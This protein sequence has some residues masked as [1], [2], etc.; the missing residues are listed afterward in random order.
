VTVSRH[1]MSAVKAALL[2]CLLWQGV[3]QAQAETDLR[4][5]SVGRN[6]SLELK[7][8]ER[9]LAEVKL[10]TPSAKRGEPKL[11]EAQVEGR[12]VVEVRVPIK[13]EAAAEVW[14][15]TVGTTA[16]TTVWSGRVGTTDRDGEAG[17]EVSVEADGL[18]LYET[19]ARIVRCDGLPVRLF[20]RK[21]DFQTRRWREVAP[22]LP[23]PASGPAI[24]ARRG[25]P[26][27]PAG[28]PRVQFPFTM[29]SAPPA[30]VRTRDI[31]QLVA[32]LALNDGDV[33][34]VWAQRGFGDGRG[35]LLT[36]RS[37]TAGQVVVGLR[38]LP[39]DTR[40]HAQFLAH[41]RPR[42]LQVVLGAGADQRF[43]VTLSDDGG[44]DSYR[45]PFWIPLP[46]PVSSSCVTVVVREVTPGS[47]ARERNTLVWGDIDVFTDLDGEKGV[48]RLVSALEGEHCEP[49][50]G[51]V[52]AVGPGALP[53]LAAALGRVQGGS[54]ECVLEAVL[55]LAPE[56]LGTEQ[57]APLAAALPALLRS[58]PADQERTVLSLLSR[59]HAPPVP[60]LAAVLRDGEAATEQRARA[61]RA[62]AAVARPE[63]WQALI[64][65][66]GSGPPELRAV[67]R[68]LCASAPIDTA[69]SLLARLRSGAGDDSARRADMVWV[70]GALAARPQ[71]K[72][73]GVRELMIELGSAAGE[74]FEVRARALMALAAW[75]EQEALAALVQVRAK[76]P[77]AALRTVAARALAERRGP[78]AT[79]ALRAAIEDSDPGVRQIA[80]EALGARRDPGAVP[81]IIAGAKQEPWPAVRRAEIAALGQLC[82]QPATDLIVRAIERDVDDVRRAAMRG[83]V[84]CRDGRAPR[85][86][87]S[88]LGGQREKPPLRTQAALLLA[89]LKDPGT[90]STLAAALER[91]LLE[92][93]ADLALEAT[94][95]ATLR[96]LA[97]VGGP[98]AL[99]AALQLRSDPRPM[100]RRSASEALG[101]LCD[102]RAGAEA[103]RA[104]TRDPDPA[105]AAAATAALRRCGSAEKHPRPRS[106]ELK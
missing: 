102:P 9:R 105:V 56:R 78:E 19:A 7:A 49:R 54:L 87:L 21:F 20:T 96:A 83:L 65:Q 68:G 70:L 80:A 11:K 41:A 39:G 15:G 29:S 79:A 67:V 97:E 90:A 13:D 17:R 22:L 51:D 40:S 72:P 60:E 53:A 48:E 10:S 1:E 62:L 58:A 85:L 84:A 71:E 12:R 44:S 98:A 92:A 8:G 37:G 4:M 77:D 88:V 32:P 28:R 14:V 55:R 75:P 81:V 86:L 64:G 31:G 100:L 16:A 30:E 3:A 6:G 25:T 24:V 93:Q 59:L 61:A 52:V 46:R 38:L 103:L 5:V 94:A 95:T 42:S 76:S 69:E 43:D 99:K 18:Y 66:L 35:E 27:M 101:K 23:P 89:E 50:V 63:A 104:A 33:E 106:P 74:A 26:G 73:A 91:L 2:L 36:A 45:Q 82:G 34:T 47:G 57:S